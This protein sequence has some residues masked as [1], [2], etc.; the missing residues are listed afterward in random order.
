MRLKNC[1]FDARYAQIAC[2]SILLGF[3]GI[4][5]VITIALLIGFVIISTALAVEYFASSRNWNQLPSALISALSLCLLLRTDSALFAAAAALLAISSKYLL[6]HAG[7]HIFNPTAL[8]L[9]I[10]TCLFD[11]AWL[12]P[13]QWGNT[14]H[15]LILVAFAGLFVTGLVT[16]IDLSLSFLFC[17]SALLLS[18]AI[19]L[20]D[21]LAIPLHQLT[22]GALLIF[23]F[24]MISDPRTSPHSRPGRLI[25]G[26]VVSVVA[27]IIH[28]KFYYQSAPI[29][30]LVLSAPLVPLLNQRFPGARFKWPRPYLPT[31][32]S[33]GVNHA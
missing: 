11:G 19:Y 27:F 31:Q 10:T 15:L 14:F 17:Y 7:Q 24:F 6:R 32:R 21:P 30:A 20:G 28:F 1:T 29:L 22:N 23:T 33:T 9:V 4:S 5:G 26:A 2:L 13:G 3:G 16:R 25:F 8:A 12:S 18:R